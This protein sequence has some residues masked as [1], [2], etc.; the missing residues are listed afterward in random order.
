MKRSWIL[1]LMAF[2][3]VFLAC[4]KVDQQAA[5]AGGGGTISG[6]TSVDEDEDDV[7]DDVPEAVN[8]IFTVAELQAL[9]DAGLPVFI[10]AEPPN[11][12]GT[13]NAGSLRITYDS[14]GNVGVYPVYMF[15]F[16][17]QTA[18][19]TV[20]L[21]YAIDDYTDQSVDNLTYI[22]GSGDCFS[23]YGLIEGTDS[24]ADC[25]YQ[26]ATVYSGCISGTDGVLGFSFGFI[27]REISGT[28]ENYLQPG[29]MRVIK[30]TD[31]L[32]TRH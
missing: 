26:R 22:A 6:V 20:Q 32:A 23:L 21:A 5:G 7:I 10:G 8:G 4:G 13:Y 31:N 24:S 2:V 28:C 25:V 1:L 9:I 3:L 27:M 14:G 17:D 18:S 12:E 30:E 16:S 19:G 15:V 29:S 11:V